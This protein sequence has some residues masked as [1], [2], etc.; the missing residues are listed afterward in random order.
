MADR[1]TSPRYLKQVELYEID[2]GTL[3]NIRFLKEAK[4]SEW[5]VKAFAKPSNLLTLK[6]VDIKVSHQQELSNA[7][8]KFTKLTTLHLSG[9]TIPGI[10]LMLSNVRL[11]LF[12]PI[13]TLDY[14]WP[15]TL[16]RL[17]LKNTCLVPDPMP[18]L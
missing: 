5:I 18:S 6:L 14:R 2:Q 7:L 15:E 1:S 13:Q 4:A 10:S 8:P 17:T 12:G 9:E 16:S 3:S 11:S